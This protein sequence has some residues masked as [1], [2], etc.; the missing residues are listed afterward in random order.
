[1]DVTSARTTKSVE[2]PLKSTEHPLPALDGLPPAAVAQFRILQQRFVA[3]LPARWQE[4]DHAVNQPA[5]QSALH[6]LAGSASSYGFDSLG[7]LARHA[8]SLTEGATS[9]D[10]TLALST[11]GLH[12]QQLQ[13][14]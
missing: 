10:L 11:L 14:A 4:I 7:Q 13:E 2:N 5:L 1:M 3:G 6:R 12:I 9:S 8:E